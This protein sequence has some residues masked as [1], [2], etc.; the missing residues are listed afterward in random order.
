MNTVYPFW[1]ITILIVLF[2]AMSFAFSRIGLVSKVAHRK[3][4]NVLLLLSF[5]I[6]GL[7]GLLMVLKVNYKLQIPAYEQLVLL[8]VDFGIGMV[9]VGLFH[10]WWHLRYFLKLFQLEKHK[11]GGTS[12]N[13]PVGDVETAVVNDFPAPSFFKVAAFL[14]G[15]T[16]IMAQVIL[17][18]EFLSVFSGNELM[19]GLVMANW[20]ILTALGA[21]LGRFPLRF[22]SSFSVV[23]TGFLLLSVLPF[24]TAFLINFLKNIVFPVGA[25]IGVFQIFFSSLILLTPFCLIGGFLFTFIAKSFSE[26]RRQNETGAIYGFESVGSVAG[27][28]LSGLLFVSV[29]SS[30]E[31]LLVLCILNSVILFFI[32]LQNKKKYIVW[33]PLAVAGAAFILLF[34]HPERR[35]RSFLYPNQ[36]IEV[37]KDSPHGNIVITRHEKMRS[38]YLNNNLLFDSENF[39]LNE[40]AVHFAM[41]QHANPTKVLL[42]SGGL[43][44]Q[45]AELKKYKTERIDY[46]ED[47]RWLLPLM[48]DSLAKITDERI[49]VQATDPL[50]FIR[51]SQQKYDVA[52][53]NLL[54]PSTMQAN[55][56]F[57]LEFYQ[58]LKQKLSADG[59]L[60]FGISSP[61]NYLN[62]EAVDLNS[63]LFVTLK[64]VFQHVLILP[65]EQN[66]FLASD[67]PLTSDIAERV[68]AKGI[69]TRYVNS[70]YIDDALLKSRSETILSALDTR[71][72]P[73]QNLKPVSYFQQLAYWLSQFKSSYWLVGLGAAALFLFFFLSGN[74][75]SRTMFVTGF[76]ASGLEILLLFGL[77]VFFGNIYLLTSFVFAG[78]MLGLGLGSFYGKQF[79]EKN[80]LPLVQLVIAVFA[81]ITGLSLFSGGMA[82]LPEAIVYALFLLATVFIG[83]LTGFQFS[84][85]SQIQ[86]GDFAE[87]SGKTYSFDLIGSAFGALAVS[88]FLVPKLGIVGSAFCIAV[89][90]VVLGFWLILKKI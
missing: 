50:R 79:Q 24:T 61:P 86:R 14:L 28:L 18:R 7:L 25:L 74:T 39:M 64:K 82:Q 43:S 62:Q 20:M 75:A 53:L 26:V 87:T 42:V 71:V 85:S 35:I 51:R 9:V 11:E 16:S 2:Y 83:G 48:K 37:S 67:A 69:E 54:N 22:R 63:T 47:N 5:L 73:N 4:W 55:R 49:S 41:L 90:N 27:G 36:Q 58:L 15:T 34:F 68:R 40:E 23:A 60:S 1:T 8:H 81:A 89:I 65:G 44:G 77:Q 88:I 33:M 66:H 84:Q 21:W 46:V 3:F 78:F 57:T 76:S 17:L 70:Y 52:I 12:R 38:V 59:V 10:F 30:F 31:S 72:Q 56:F 45:I 32:S 80:L 6:S 29:L 19:I 13:T